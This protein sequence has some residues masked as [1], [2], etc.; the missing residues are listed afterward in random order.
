MFHSTPSLPQIEE[1]S[2]GDDLTLPP[3]YL[4]LEADL[5]QAKALFDAEDWT[6]KEQ[7]AFGQGDGFR[8]YK[9]ALARVI[10]GQNVSNA[11]LK[12]AEIM[13]DL[14]LLPP[15][16]IWLFDNASFPGSF[17]LAVHHLA[18]TQKKKLSWFASSLLD[19]EEGILGD[20]YKLYENYKNNW[21]M[22]E[23]NNGDV[24]NYQNIE[25]WYDILGD[26][27]INLYTSDL[28][29]QTSNDFDKQESEHMMAQFGQ[30]VSGLRVLRKGGNFV[31]KHFSFFQSFNVSWIRVLSSYFETFGIY[32]PNTSRPTNSEVYFVG[33]GFKGINTSDLEFF[34]ERMEQNDLSP[35]VSELEPE[36]MEFIFRAAEAIYSRQ[37]NDIRTRVQL[38]RNG[39]IDKLRALGQV[40]VNEWKKKYR[41]DKLQNRQKLKV[42][43]CILKKCKHQKRASDK[44]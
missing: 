1:F 34:Y 36:F 43:E 26:Q 33:K 2:S 5:N 14:N 32:K 41:L 12:C 39:E 10:N 7:R 19:D 6:E 20:D 27:E 16:K 23:D 42:K 31:T 30:D 37:A 24:T 9:I 29:F 15:S 21:L 17:I 18:M 35:L 13:L 8:S 4:A 40:K 3:K 11:W 25:D 38:V 44:H 22:D 28:G